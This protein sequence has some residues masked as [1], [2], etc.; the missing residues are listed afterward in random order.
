[1]RKS[2]INEDYVLGG[3]FK[4]NIRLKLT[5]VNCYQLIWQSNH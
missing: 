4:T 1:M 3:T 2:V 5:N